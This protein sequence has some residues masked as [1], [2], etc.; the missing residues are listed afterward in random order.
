MPIYVQLRSDGLAIAYSDLPSGVSGPLLVPVESETAAR[1]ALGKVRSGGGWVAAPAAPRPPRPLDEA[2]LIDLCQSAG[3][4]TDAQLIAAD[5]D[6]A[7]R[8]FWIKLRAASVILPTD[9]RVQDGL[10]AVEALGY[11]PAGAAAVLDAWPTH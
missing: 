3:A 4:M 8:A 2:A 1:E 6:P 9:P 7:L 5:A 10:A 11:L